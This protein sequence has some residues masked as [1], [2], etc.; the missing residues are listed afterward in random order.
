MATESSQLRL[1]KNGQESALDNVILYRLDLAFQVQHQSKEHPGF[2]R[3]LPEAWATFV[4][5][6]GYPEP[7]SGS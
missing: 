7:V 1:P 4:G 6:N 2:S 5:R 3:A